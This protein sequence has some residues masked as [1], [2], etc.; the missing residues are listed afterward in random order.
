MELTFAKNAQGLYE[1]TFE[2]TGDFALHLERPES[3]EINVRQRHGN[4]GEY[5]KVDDFQHQT[6]KK[7]IDTTFVDAVYP[8]NIKIESASAPTLAVVTFK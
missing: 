1:A 8:V 5:A 7:V 4:A 6:Y 3:G 2:A